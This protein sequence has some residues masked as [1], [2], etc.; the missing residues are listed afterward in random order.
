[1]KLPIANVQHREPHQRPAVGLR[2]VEPNR[3]RIED[4]QTRSRLKVHIRPGPERLFEPEILVPVEFDNLRIKDFTVMKCHPLAECDFQGTVIET[5]PTGGQARH[6]RDF[7]TVLDEVLEY[8]RD[9]I[10]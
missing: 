3:L 7:F 1:M 2:K 5:A 9:Y 6:Q 8:V 4:V 10:T